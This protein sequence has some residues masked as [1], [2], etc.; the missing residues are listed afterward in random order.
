M[1][2]LKLKYPFSLASELASVVEAL[3]AFRYD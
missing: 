1:L 3:M 2:Y